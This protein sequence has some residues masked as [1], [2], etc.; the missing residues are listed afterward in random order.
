MSE[1]HKGHRSTIVLLIRHKLSNNFFTSVSFHK[2]VTVTG[3]DRRIAKTGRSNRQNKQVSRDWAILVSL[4]SSTLIRDMQ[5]C[6]CSFKT[7]WDERKY[8][9]RRSKD[10]RPPVP[11][12][13]QHCI[14]VWLLVPFSLAFDDEGLSLYLFQV[15][16]IS[17]DN[18][19]KA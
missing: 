9:V 2:T 1:H 6:V 8:T 14:H 3:L 16:F 18:K 17:D 11:D 5:K 13:W 7:R 15:I 19:L 4:F 10:V 12:A